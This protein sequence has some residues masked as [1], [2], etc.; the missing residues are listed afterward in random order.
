MNFSGFSLI[1]KCPRP[2]MMVADACAP[3]DVKGA[4]AGAGIVVFTG[5]QE[6]RDTA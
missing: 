3:G 6:E 4:F 2:C 5:E 1:G